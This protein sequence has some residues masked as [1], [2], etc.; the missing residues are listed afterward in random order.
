MT[1]KD[2]QEFKKIIKE[3]TLEVL[4]SREGQEAIKKGSL[5]ALKSE[6][7]KEILMDNFI[8]GFNEVIVPVFEDYGD[9]IKKME[10]KMGV[11]AF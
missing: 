3:S 6:E 10:R 8:E 7:G 9:R 4:N 2:Q 1:T 5:A 11:A